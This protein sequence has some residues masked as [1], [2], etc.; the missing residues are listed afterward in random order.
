MIKK[1]Q[2]LIVLLVVLFS[3]CEKVEFLPTI[4][5]PVFTA[6]I[7]FAKSDSIS[8]NAGDDLYY[9]YASHAEIEDE[10]I[11]S[12]LFGKDE[13]C[14]SGCAENFA[15]QFHQKKSEENRLT[16]GNY[17]FYSVPRNGYKHNYSL[18]TN[19]QNPLENSSWRVGSEVLSG[20]SISIDSNNDT[21]LGDGM[22]LIYNIPDVLTVQFERQILPLS[23]ECDISLNFINTNDGIK[24]EVVTSSPFAQVS[25]STG[26]IS[27][28][29]IINPNVSI[30]TA[31]VFSGSGCT[32]DIVIN[33][34]DLNL[35]DGY[36]IGFNQ[37]SFA[38]STPDNNNN[39]VSI[40]YTTEDG[41]FYTSSTIGQILPFRFD[42]LEITDYEVNELGDPTWMIKANF[43]CIL[44]GENGGTRRIKNGNA[45]FAVSHQ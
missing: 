32:T 17:D 11:Y 14:E 3:S 6:G 23:V 10:I 9:M 28:S 2:M 34:A 25:W 44:F 1:L 42:V 5:E 15:I 30:Y 41:I 12:G 19:D 36:N 20:E 8:F 39:A 26:A 16:K 13:S 24:I 33:I 21:A 43:D 22:R 35:L 7:P 29:I 37:S 38:F 40:S 18:T 45:V 31:R 4:E 27:N